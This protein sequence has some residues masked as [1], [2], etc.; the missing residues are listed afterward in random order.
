VYGWQLGFIAVRPD[1]IKWTLHD[2]PESLNREMLSI[3]R[4]ETSKRIFRVFPH[5]DSGDAT[6]DYWAP[7]YLVDTQ[8]RE[9]S[10]QALIAYVF[11]SQ[12][13]VE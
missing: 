10:T 7:G 9:Y 6:G 5:L 13:K 3:I 2:F 4:R 12:V 8:N 1:Y 11:K